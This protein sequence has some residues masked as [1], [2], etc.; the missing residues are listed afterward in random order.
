MK[1]GIFALVSLCALGGCGGSAPSQPPVPLANAS[2]SGSAPRRTG[3]APVDLVF[4]MSGWELWIGNDQLAQLAP[5][6]PTRFAGALERVQAATRAANLAQRLP[7][8]SR[9]TVITYDDDAHVIVAGVRAETFTATAFG[10]QSAYFRKLGN[11]LVAGVEAGLAT[12]RETDSAFR[13]VLVVLGD[14][15]SYDDEAAK[16]ALMEDRKQGLRDGVEVVA[17]TYSTPMS[18]EVVAIRSFTP[19]VM[20]SS[21]AVDFQAKL[22]RALQQLTP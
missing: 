9:V 2:A 18:S 16:T 6:D 20:V 5:G 17:I 22:E 15:N 10:S 1:L 14:G 12:L 3:G 11:N 8:G 4:V 19:S 21:D 7:G 13:D